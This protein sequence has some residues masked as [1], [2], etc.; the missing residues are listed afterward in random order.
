MAT[1]QE[2]VDRKR[3]NRAARKSASAGAGATRP[4]LPAMPKMKRARKPKAP[5]QCACG[6]GGETR[7]GR[8]IPGHDAR[9]HGWALRVTRGLV[10]LAD[11]EKS[12]GAGT[13]KAVAAH[14]AAGGGDKSAAAANPKAGRKR[15]RKP[16]GAPAATDVSEPNLAA[17][18]AINAN[19]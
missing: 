8:F 7:G 1:V 3:A 13:R 15:D 10:T 11:V 17:S 14:I 6:C 2:S 16:K 4:P 9:L 12:D 5:Q 18:E 19:A